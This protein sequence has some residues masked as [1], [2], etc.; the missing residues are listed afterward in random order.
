MQVAHFVASSKGW[1]QDRH[2]CQSQLADCRRTSESVPL[3][4]SMICCTSYL[5]KLCAEGESASRADCKRHDRRHPISAIS[6]RTRFFVESH[7]P[8]SRA[9]SGRWPPSQVGHEHQ[10]LGFDAECACTWFRGVDGLLER[11]VRIRQRIL[12]ERAGDVRLWR[13]ERVAG[14]VLAALLISVV[15]ANVLWPGPPSP[16]V[17]ELRM[18][19]S[20]SPFPTF[21]LG[22]T[23][24][25]ARMD[26]NANLSMRLL[27][28]SLQGIVNRAAVELYLDVPTGVAGNTSQTLSY[29]AA[30]YNV[31]YDV[32]SAQAAIDAYI[33][34]AAG[35]VVYDSSRPESIDVG[36]VLAGQQNAVLAGPDLAGWLFNRYAL[37]TLFD[38]AKRPD[39]TSLE[40][41]G[42]Y[43]RATRV[44]SPHPYPS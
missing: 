9:E 12:P 24:R 31:T 39:W 43:E 37:P 6:A 17:A 13:R 33:H 40:P 27:M 23:L 16:A 2:G 32:M 18:P 8:I 7:N 28:T 44:L 11:V 29:L 30:R 21:P 42:A 1:R 4:P 38:Y 25:A 34:R 36:T 41:V 26:A 14:G 10:G 15:L 20:Q 22:P 3:Q 5:A 19:P 35:V